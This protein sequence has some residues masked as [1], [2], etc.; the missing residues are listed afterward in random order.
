MVNKSVISCLCILGFFTGWGALQSVPGLGT[1]AIAQGCH[2][3]YVGV[4]IAPG[5]S[6]VDC[7]GGSG[8][9][10]RYARGPFRVVG[11]DQYRLDRDRDGIG[12]ERG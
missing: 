2:P 1:Q 9:G 5:N 3:S 7:A 8:N 4:C 6:D 12:C 11:F 10:P